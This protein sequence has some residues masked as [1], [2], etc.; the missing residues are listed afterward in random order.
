MNSFTFLTEKRDGTIRARV[1]SNGGTQRSYIDKHG[2]T[3]PIATTEALMTTEGIHAKQNRD[4]ITL[5]IPNAFVQ[6][7]VRK[8]EEK[9]IMKIKGLLVDY[10]ANLF[11]TKCEDYITTQI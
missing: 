9:V 3:S 2:A 10:L 11:L 4:V 1:C 6:R 7:P 8:S 5:N